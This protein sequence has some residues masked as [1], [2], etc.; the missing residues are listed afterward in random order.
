MMD[1]FI[2]TSLEFVPVFVNI[3]HSGQE[4]KL[5]SFTCRMLE[6][7]KLIIYQN[8]KVFEKFDLTSK[9]IVFVEKTAVQP[10]EVLA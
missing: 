10:L 3:L 2:H 5:R 6:K 4:Y 7:N 1:S 9:I 8:N